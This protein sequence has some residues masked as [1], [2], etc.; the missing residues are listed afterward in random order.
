MWAPKRRRLIDQMATELDS[1]EWRM[2]GSRFQAFQ[3]PEGAAQMRKPSEWMVVVFLVRQV[4]V[5]AGRGV[6]AG[7]G[8]MSGLRRRRERP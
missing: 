7:F 3:R 6:K 2:L 4:V 8:L 1:S 5:G